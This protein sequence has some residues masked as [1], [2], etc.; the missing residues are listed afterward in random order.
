MVYRNDTKKTN[1]LNHKMCCENLT[2]SG[3]SE[4]FEVSA[5]ER[6]GNCDKYVSTHP[7][8]SVEQNWYTVLSTN[9]LT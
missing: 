5:N 7:V 4:C 9:I 2:D 1:E 8:G 6:V 3:I